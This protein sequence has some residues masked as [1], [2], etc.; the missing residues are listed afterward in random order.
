MNSELEKIDLLRARLGVSYKEAKEALDEAEGDVVQALIKLE[1]SSLHLKEKIHGR[2]KEAVSQL[3]NILE[4]GQK[5][6]IKIKKDGKTIMDL[7]ATVGVAGLVGALYST[8]LAVLGAVGAIAA[9]ANDYTMEIEH[10]EKENNI[11]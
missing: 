4:T 5:T 10:G 2:S 3:R 7:P 9:M 8:E 1:Q 6:R 11:I